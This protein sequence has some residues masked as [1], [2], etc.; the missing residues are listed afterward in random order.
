ML[1]DTAF[2]YHF[3]GMPAF[4]MSVLLSLQIMADIVVVA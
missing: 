2:K 1:N 4:V 3:L